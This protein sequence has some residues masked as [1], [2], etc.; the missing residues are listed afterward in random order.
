MRVESRTPDS[1]REEPQE[2]RSYADLQAALIRLGFTKAQARERLAGAVEWLEPVNEEVTDQNV[3]RW[4]LGF[5][6]PPESRTP[7]KGRRAVV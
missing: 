4:A 7:D 1:G 5:H 6:D 3:L 2:E